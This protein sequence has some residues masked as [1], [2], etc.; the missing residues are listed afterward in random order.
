MKN[1]N[2]ILAALSLASLLPNKIFAQVLETEESKPLAAKQFEIGTGLEFQKS[3]EGTETALP[4]AIEYG[5]S[6]KFTL[7]VEPVG[8]TNIQPKTGT[9]AKG[10]GDLE[11]TLF[12]QVLAE[13]KS[14]P[15]S[16]VRRRGGLNW[17]PVRSRSA[18]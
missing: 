3:K 9:V 6:E 13:K 17:P 5:L 12:Y 8:F 1:A 15:S 4:L 11:V 7:L 14:F 18:M 16:R 10:I 2:I